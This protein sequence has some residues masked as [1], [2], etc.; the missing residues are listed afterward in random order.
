[1]ILPPF[2]NQGLAGPWFVLG[3]TAKGRG[4]HADSSEGLRS[5]TC[6]HAQSQSYQWDAGLLVAFCGSCAVSA[7]ANASPLPPLRLRK[8]PWAGDSQL[9]P[10]RANAQ[11]PANSAFLR[12]LAQNPEYKGGQR[13]YVTASLL[14]ELERDGKVL[15]DQEYPG[16]PMRYQLA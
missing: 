16:G 11:V 2:P 10:P 15:K 6:S 3:S 7:P 13:N 8:S 4:E 14:D 1:M 12:I 5:E 9:R